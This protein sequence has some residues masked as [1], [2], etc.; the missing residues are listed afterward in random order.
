MNSFSAHVKFPDVIIIEELTKVGSSVPILSIT[1]LWI[2]FSE[3]WTAEKVLSL[4]KVISSQW[5]H[6]SHGPYKSPF[7]FVLSVW[8]LVWFWCICVTIP[9]RERWRSLGLEWQFLES[10]WQIKQYGFNNVDKKLVWG[11]EVS[12]VCHCTSLHR[13]WMGKAY[14]TLGQSFKR[15]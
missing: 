15:L 5:F 1:L 10:L 11:R 12:Y 14:G 8:H 7:W 4:A 9:H 2:P 13:G 3:T 6:Q